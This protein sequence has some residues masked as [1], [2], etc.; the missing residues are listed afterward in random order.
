[1]ATT[2]DWMAFVLALNR[3]DESLPLLAIHQGD[4]ALA[5]SPHALR[6]RPSG[7]SA[8]ISVVSSEIRL[9]CL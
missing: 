1:M 3:I 9:R 8:G 6:I 2:S 5:A 7:C 4:V